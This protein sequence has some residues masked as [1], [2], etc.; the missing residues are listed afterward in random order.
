V[1]TFRVLGALEV[2][3]GDRVIELPR[4]KQRKLLSALLLR[5]GETVPTD[6]LIEQ[7][8]GQRPPR[9][10]KEALVNNV[11]LLRKALGADALLT[12]EPGYVLLVEP[13]S[14]DVGQFERLATA[15]RATVS[16]SE[17]VEKLQQALALWH[18]APFADIA[19][20]SFAQLEISRLEDLRLAARQD[21]IDA[22][23]EL[24]NYADLLPQLDILIQQH[25]FDERLRGQQMLALYR[26]GRQAEALDA[27]Q[28]T[29][30]LLDEELGLEPGSDLKELEAA[31][32]RQ[33]LALATPKAAPANAQPSRRTVTVL[34]AD[35]VEASEFAQRLDP[36]ALQAVLNK[37][38]AAM[39]EAIERHG[40]TV[41]KFIGDAVMAV[42]GVPRSHEDDALRA[43]RAAV[44]I[45]NALRI[46]EGGLE[47][48]IGVNTGEVFTGGETALVTGGTVNMAKRLEQAAP[49][50]EILLGAPT[51]RLIRDAVK[52]EPAETLRL[53]KA[54]SVLAFRIAEV[55]AGVPGIA[56][57]FDLPLIGRDQELAQLISAYEQA[58]DERRCRLVTVL[59]EA[60]IGKTRL[61][62][63]FVSSVGDD[64]TVLIGRCV[65]YGEGATYLPLAEM[66]EDIDAL[67]ANTISTEEIALAVRKRFEE[68][69]CLRPLVLIF[70]DLHWAERT[71]IDLIAHVGELA[72]GQILSLCLARPEFIT[73]HDMTVEAVV[74]LQPLLDRYTQ[75]MVVSLEA[76]LAPGL[77]SR[78]VEIAEG[79]P[80]FV[81]QLVAY[82]RDEGLGSLG[83]VPS[84]IEAVLASRLDLLAPEDQG[85]LRRAAVVGREFTRRAVGALGPIE[86][87]PRLEEAG[88][89]HGI[90]DE[91][92]FH[93]VL[94][95]D[96]AYAAIPLVQRAELHLRFADWLADQPTRSDEIVGY[97]LEQ[98]HSYLLALG[99]MDDRALEIA[100]RARTHLAAAGRAAFARDDVRAA[101]N[102]LARALALEKPDAASVSLRLDL[103]D[104]VYLAGDSDQA[105]AIANQAAE[106]ATASAD[107]VGTLRARLQ[108]AGLT[109]SSGWDSSSVGSLV[110]LAEEA[111]PVFEKAGDEA[112]LA[113][114]LLLTA[115]V[116]MARCKY[117]SAMALLE[118]AA[119]HARRAGDFRREHE[120]VAST[121]DAHLWGPTP[122]AEAIQWL[123]ALGSAYEQRPGILRL[124]AALQAM[125]GRFDDARSLVQDAS[126][127]NAELGIPAVVGADERWYVETLAENHG[128]AEREAR[129]SCECRE[130]SG[131][132]GWLSTATC[133]LASSLCALGRDDEAGEAVALAQEL[134][135][136]DDI[137]NQIFVRRVRARLAARRGEQDLAKELGHEAIALAGQTDHLNAHADAFM[138]L[139]E[140]LQLQG[141]E[142]AVTVLD[143]ALRLYKRKGNLVMAERTRRRLTALRS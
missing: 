74:S 118:R 69:A 109:L 111:R 62:Q 27:Y 30:R 1:L 90:G 100:G 64:A 24:G 89:V 101:A 81:E 117:G 108:V 65:S 124:H 12:R 126:K 66:I 53:G 59:G 49:A 97:H 23:L 15:A 72:Q 63:E 11:S 18:G 42:F 137:L 122:A 3:D 93:H 32:L 45:H 9:T 39:R 131:D 95:R 29:R 5:A 26:A 70:E 33:D 58:R 36:E 51:L 133:Y 128:A 28:G 134:S 139:A 106:R 82:A 143:Q 56:R 105:V 119:D 68:L 92:R 79:N 43:V 41:E 98:A 37:Y 142:E 17:R 84:S 46:L 103:A 76:E 94:V 50:G 54:E 73:E 96:V 112:G 102:L 2:R 86:R 129:F 13:E 20:E 35:L 88:L 7:L 87:L 120:A 135:A 38:F 138:D 77:Q 19:F 52:A 130:R 123:V 60:G 99:A 34:F 125:L 31:I 107:A 67:I 8:W 6:T 110:D 61:A 91:Y 132:R 127:R 136:D 48:R 121:A 57:R 140:V 83:T 40:G 113:E 22:E 71:L 114:V 116:E 80:L 16:G 44:D 78:I 75:E 10:A 14:I 25:P 55:K 104:A 21:L 47:A 4:G 141:S 85:V 115:D